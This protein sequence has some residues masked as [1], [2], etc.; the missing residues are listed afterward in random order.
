METRT[1]RPGRSAATPARGAARTSMHAHVA[2]RLR[3]LVVEC[4]IP[5]GARLN[6]TA[7]C[8]RLGVSRTPLREALKVLASEGLVVIHP[9]RGAAVSTVTAREAAE[10]FQVMAALEALI[11][12]RLAA[13]ATARDLRDLQA[14]HARMRAL[15]EADRRADYYLANEAF[16]RRLAE[17]AG[18][19]VL[20][21]VHG[22]LAS[23]LRRARYLANLSHERWAEA[24]DEHAGILEA[25]ERRDADALARAM[26]DHMR[27]TCERV[28]A[29]LAELEQ[30][31]ADGP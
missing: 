5:P 18:N 2:D 12:R 13:H 19:G 22:G 8:E 24:V 10:L 11:G 9:N 3:T 4:R 23:R 26:A 14:L 6:E 7:L 31:A 21:A 17:T 15:H 16:H 1:R 29:G 30:A 27:A 25:L 28:V 20:L